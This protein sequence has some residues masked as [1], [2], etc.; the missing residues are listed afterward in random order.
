MFSACSPEMM[1]IMKDVGWSKSF[2]GSEM[3]RMRA[4]KLTLLAIILIPALCLS[5]CQSGSE[6]R[7]LDEGAVTTQATTET[8]SPP[9]P[10]DEELESLESSQEPVVGQETFDKWSHY[11]APSVGQVPDE[12]FDKV[13]RLLAD[14]NW[15][16]LSSLC[17]EE[18]QLRSYMQLYESD[19]LDRG[20]FDQPGPIR[21]VFEMDHAPLEELVS[22]Y[23]SRFAEFA[24]WA[25]RHYLDGWWGKAS[26]T[27]HGYRDMPDAQIG[28]GGTVASNADWKLGLVR[29]PEGEIKVN[30]FIFGAH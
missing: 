19:Q 15:S 11:A 7:V 17:T 24:E 10:M 21:Y 5:G 12:L 3:I 14:E 27:G 6:S 2:Y 8:L 23:P 16:E 9:V 18:V 25:S 1:Y 26:V 4:S 22:R 28:I 30:S 29:T 13:I 20:Y